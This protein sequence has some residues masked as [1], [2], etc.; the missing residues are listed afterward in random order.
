MPTIEYG[1]ITGT[2]QQRATPVL[3]HQGSS[4]HIVSWKEGKRHGCTY[5]ACSF[6]DLQGFRCLSHDER[7]KVMAQ[8]KEERLA[9]HRQWLADNAESV[10]EW[11]TAYSLANKERIRIRNAASYAANPEKFR[12]RGRTRYAANPEEGRA[13]ATAARI[14]DPEKHRVSDNK[15]KAIHREETNAKQRATYAANPEKGKA[16]S[17]AWQKENPEKVIANKARC[18]ARR[19]NAPVND[20]SAAQWIAMQ[21]LYDH[22]CVYCGKRCKGKLTK[23]H[24]TP[25][26]KGGSHTLSNILPACKNCNSRKGN[27]AILISV[28]PLLLAPVEKIPP[29]RKRKSTKRKK[30]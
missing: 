2:N 6:P 18:R 24:I 23:D 9:K 8:T 4:D 21:I 10:K 30:G 11:Q 28:Q 20:F 3:T 27:R 7:G 17:V 16:T 13:R 15:S 5:S 1:I 14:K 12:A 19:Y 22:R 29:K 25:L 26:S